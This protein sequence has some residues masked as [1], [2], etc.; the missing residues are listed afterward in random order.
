GRCDPRRVSDEGRDARGG[1]LDRD[2]R[3][4]DEVQSEARRRRVH[5][6]G[7]RAGTAVSD[8]RFGAR[9]VA[10]ALLVAASSTHAASLTVPGTTA[11]VEASGYVDGLAVAE[12]GG[13]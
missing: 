8:A 13:P 4:Q 1:Q 3:R 2:R 9:L 12:I 6:A 10:V 11:R 7:S 5:R